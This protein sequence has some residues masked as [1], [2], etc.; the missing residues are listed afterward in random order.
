MEIGQMPIIGDK[1]G[2]FQN[3]P[4]ITCRGGEQ[5]EYKL[6]C[7]LC[8]TFTSIK[9]KIQDNHQYHACFEN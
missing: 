7:S 3:P 1:V 4:L 6:A 5:C 9:T 2:K 8:F